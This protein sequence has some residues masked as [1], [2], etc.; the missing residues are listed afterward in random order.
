MSID[1]NT[2]IV[3]AASD[4]SWGFGILDDLV[5]VYED[6]LT[7]DERESIEKA[8]DYEDEQ[9]IWNIL[10]NTADAKYACHMPD[11]PSN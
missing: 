4:G 7:D 9:K 3:W 5:V 10:L 1:G 8:A 11:S 6:D 2:K